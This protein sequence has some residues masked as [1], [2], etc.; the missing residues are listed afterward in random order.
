MNAV[1]LFSG[2]RWHRMLES[3]DIVHWP[4]YWLSR[5]MVRTGGGWIFCR[6]SLILLLSVGMHSLLEDRVGAIAGSFRSQ[7][8]HERRVLATFSTLTSL[9]LVKHNA[10]CQ[11]NVWNSESTALFVSAAQLAQ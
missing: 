1:V 7:H 6:P 9:R 3:C 2:M 11:R 8:S 5:S 10:T 4:N